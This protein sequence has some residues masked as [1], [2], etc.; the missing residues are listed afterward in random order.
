MSNDQSQKTEQPSHEKLKK[1]RQ[2]GDVPKSR[3]L[4][5]FISVIVGCLYI[6]FSGE[7]IF[8]DFMQLF[9]DC[10]LLIEKINNDTNIN[11]ITE[12]LLKRGIELTISITSGIVL[13]I[14]IFLILSG[15][16]YS[17]PI[18]S[19]KP[20]EPKMEKLNPVKGLQN[21]FSKDKFIELI[22]SVLKIAVLSIVFVYIFLKI[23]GP[24]IASTGKFTTA[25]I[26]LVFNE[27]FKTVVKYSFFVL[28]FFTFIDMLL[29]RKQYMK[30]MM[31]SV[32]EKKEEAKQQ[33]GDPL[34][35]GQRQEI[36]REI[37]A[38]DI[39]E[40][41]KTADVVV[42]NPVHYAV[43]L[44]YDIEKDNAPVV[45]IKGERLV[46]LNIAEIARKLAVPVIR[47]E[48]LTRSLMDVENGDEIPEEF[49][50]AAASV[51]RFIMELTHTNHKES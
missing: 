3:E 33:E 40:S 47:D 30:K 22:F 23:S 28:V 21:I 5:S 41:V 8:K 43:A 27:S 13:L 12:L 45:I 25:K 1:A 48:T 20:L 10:F 15:Y 17:R 46:A 18:I 32:Q 4:F 51:F 37:A 9:K 14:I 26:G 36:H 34:F 11:L 6:I 7:D 16:S 2:K 42:V 49:Y 24:L 44:K 19:F 31:M 50:L 29:K 39:K 35:K 38:A